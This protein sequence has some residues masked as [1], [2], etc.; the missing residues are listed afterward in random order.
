MNKKQIITVFPNYSPERI[1]PPVFIKKCPFCGNDERFFFRED[2]RYELY[3]AIEC[4]KCDARGPECYRGDRGKNYIKDYNE[5]LNL[6]IQAWNER[7]DDS[8]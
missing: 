7:A 4:Y 3:G 1:E 5:W 8:E 6:V 2:E